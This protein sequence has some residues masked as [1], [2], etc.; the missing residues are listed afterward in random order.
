[1]IHTL[2]VSRIS[3]NGIPMLQTLFGGQLQLRTNKKKK[4]LNTKAKQTEGDTKVL[5]VKFRPLLFTRRVLW[6][7]KVINV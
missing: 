7:S 1:M 2:F 4:T 6:Q 3:K 5:G